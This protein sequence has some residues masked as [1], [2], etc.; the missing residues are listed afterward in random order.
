MC[1]K[2]HFPR[3]DKSENTFLLVCA[4]HKNADSVNVRFVRIS[5]LKRETLP[6]LKK[7]R[8][9]SLRLYSFLL[10]FEAGRTR[11]EFGRLSGKGQILSILGFLG[12]TVLVPTTKLC[13]YH[14]KTVIDI[15]TN[16]CGGFQ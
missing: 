6:V 5:F 3:D 7:K 14:V 13:L 16:Q 10:Y 2:I 11:A 1:G 9:H 4:T 15:S 8:F 12:Y